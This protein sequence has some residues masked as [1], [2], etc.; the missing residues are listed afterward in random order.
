MLLGPVV[1]VPWPVSIFGAVFRRSAD[2]W[3]AGLA[4]G[5]APV[6]VAF[7]DEW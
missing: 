3:D 2:W 6:S 1:L 7:S 5:E 4:M